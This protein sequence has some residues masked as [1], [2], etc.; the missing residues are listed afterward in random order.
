MYE[1]IFN[2]VE[3]KYVLTNKQKDELLKMI[4]KYLEKDL[5][6]ESL[7]SNIYFDDY[8]NRLIINSLEKPLYK[9]KVRLRGYGIINKD[10]NVFF[11]IKNKYM[12][13]VGKRRIMIKLNDLYDYLEGKTLPD[14]QIMKELDYLIK[15]YNLKPS[16][17]ISYHRFSY[18]GKDDNIRITFDDNLISRRNDLKLENGVYGDKHFKKDECIMEIKTLNGYPIWLV[19]ALSSLNIYPNSFSKYGFIYSKEMKEVLYA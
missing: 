16:I 11:E 6:F 1:N 4:N 9:D 5:Y 2:R 7:I 15:I 10:S 8:N 13:I 12:G 3:Q 19:N 14:K 17:F 18:K